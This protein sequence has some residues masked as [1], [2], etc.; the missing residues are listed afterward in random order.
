[1]SSQ[2][3]PR[4]PVA[5]RPTPLMICLVCVATLFVGCERKGKVWKPKKEKH[6]VHT[7]FYPTT[8]FTQRIAGDHVEVV[9]PCPATEDPIFWMPDDKTLAAYQQADLIVI[10]GA[11]YEKW[12]DKV[13]LPQSRIVD[14]TKPMTDSLITFALAVQHSHGPKG[15]HAHAGIDG[16]TWLDPVNAKA[17]AQE[18]AQ[19]LI[20]LAPEHATAFDRGLA[21]LVKDLDGLDMRLRALSARLEKVSLL[22]S[23]PAYNYIARRYGWQIRNL[24]L[25][26]QETPD[27]K[28]LEEIKQASVELSTHWLLWEANP[29]GGIANAVHDA[30]GVRSLVFSPCETMDDEAS[31]DGEDYFSVMRANVA[32]LEQAMS[33]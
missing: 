18:I 5:C 8:Y 20:R 33:P 2:H 12:I 7:T 24:H 27:A 13:S 32:A 10:N 3:Q 11:S 31:R 28:A 1:M 9:C 23:H 4:G 25:D 6:V 21:D 30:T 15:E 16:H 19:A 17:Q 14:T 29:A 22:C 26:P